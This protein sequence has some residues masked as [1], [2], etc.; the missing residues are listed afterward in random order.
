MSDDAEGR[1]F[2]VGLAL[3][4]GG[5]MLL[6]AFGG[7]G[8]PAFLATPLVGLGG[9]EGFD[10]LVAARFCFAKLC[11][12]NSFGTLYFKQILSYIS[13]S[14]PLYLASKVGTSAIL[15]GLCR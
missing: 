13:G 4:G 15:A 3:G 8:A 7:V 12:T 1:F 2:V 14:T 5:G 9:F 6:G 11:G 10:L